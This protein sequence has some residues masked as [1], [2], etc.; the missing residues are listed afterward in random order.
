MS[1]MNKRLIGLATVLAISLGAGAVR[2]AAQAQAALSQAPYG[3]ESSVASEAVGRWLY[4]AQGNTI[5]SVRGV[6]DG[7]RTAVIMVGSYFRPGSYEARVPARA[8]TIV[9]G[10]VTLQ[11]ETVQALNTRSHS[12]G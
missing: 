1:T 7:G 11:E 6:E 9:N 8:I 5:G 3:S 12:R 10:K 2:D 4:D